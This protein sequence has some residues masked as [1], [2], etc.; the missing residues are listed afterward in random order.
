MFENL[1]PSMLA[2]MIGNFSKGG[3]L[4]SLVNTEIQKSLR[5]GKEYHDRFHKNLCDTNVSDISSDFEIGNIAG[6]WTKIVLNS[7]DRLG[8]MV[9]EKPI[10]EIMAGMMSEYYKKIEGR[11]DHSMIYQSL[12]SNSCV[13]LYPIFVTM[14][15]MHVRK[16]L[17]ENEWDGNLGCVT[18]QVQHSLIM[19]GFEGN[20]YVQKVADL[21]S[22]YFGVGAMIDKQDYDNKFTQFKA[23]VSSGEAQAINQLR[24]RADKDPDD[25]ELFDLISDGMRSIEETGKEA[26]AEKAGESFLIDAMVL[27]RKFGLLLLLTNENEISSEIVERIML[28]FKDFNYAASDK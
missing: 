28:E 23:L 24:A 12:G 19:G 20:E 7:L 21:L 4:E 16:H 3:K 15:G 9:I 22:G 1:D 5:A 26:K 8:V 2:R 18:S 13:S 10:E 11:G 25:K 6:G 14:T 17:G 27:C